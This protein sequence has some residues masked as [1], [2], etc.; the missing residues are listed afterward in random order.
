MAGQHTTR[1]RDLTGQRFGRLTVIERIPN[2]PGNT[3]AIW[4]C[5]C[6]CGNEK[7]KSSHGLKRA[8]APSCG[9]WGRERISEAKGTHRQTDSKEYYCWSAMKQRCSNPKN[10]MYRHYGGR[11]IQVCERW[12]DSFE[13]FLG[14]MGFA[15]PGMSIDRIDNDGNYEPGNCQWATPTQQIRNRSNCRYLTARGE[16]MLLSDWAVK[17]GVRK[18]TIANRLRYGWSEEEAIFG[19]GVTV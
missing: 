3:C 10:K 16:T 2:R 14:D 15:P 6:D 18:G 17:A 1:A 13:A 9:C 11:G 19:K 7:V 5:I 4:R 12:D 8:H